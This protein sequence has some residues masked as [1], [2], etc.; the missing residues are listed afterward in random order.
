MRWT[1]VAAIWA[2][3]AALGAIYFVEVPPP[4]ERGA[5]QPAAGTT[6]GSVAYSV[7][8][9]AVRAVELRRGATIVR[10][11]RTGE[12]P[13]RV[14]IPVERNIQGGLLDAF[15]EQLAANGTGE[16]IDGN[17]SDDS[18]GL[19]QP[20]FTVAVEAADGQRLSLVIGARTPT[21]TAA[22]ARREGDPSV[23]L[24]GRNLVYYA[25]LVF[26]AAR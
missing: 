6:A 23:L 7:E 2:A 26:D 16:R 14:T 22:Y 21:G 3:A 12:G 9:R 1:H 8:P 20:N 24:V 4:P 5:G 18:F 25:D 10:W 11:E 19:A 15:I 13:W 17:P